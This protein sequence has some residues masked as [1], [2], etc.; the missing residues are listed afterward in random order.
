MERFPNYVIIEH[1]DSGNNGHLFQAFD[2]STENSLAFK[3][4]PVENLPKDNME[5]HAYLNEARKA[6]QITHQS[7]VTYIDV[8]PY[9]D[10]KTQSEYVVF[11]CNYIE[12]RNLNVYMSQP[13]ADINMSFVETF[14]RTMFELLY[15]LKRRRLQ[16]GDL[17]AGNVLVATSEF[18]VYARPTFRVT[19]FGV[20]ELTGETA[21]G[22]DYLHVAEI[23][24][25]LLEK[26]QYGDCEGRDRYAYDIL[27]QEFLARH[28]IETDSST[29]H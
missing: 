9:E 5:Q 11:V 18:D 1:I 13:R 22:N 12:G 25:Q 15:E 10:T 4:V 28:L 23:L 16:H 20:R 7:V 27:R 8:F 19:D 6:N 14:L 21:H 24:R 17:H 3:F 2:S 29:D 26:I